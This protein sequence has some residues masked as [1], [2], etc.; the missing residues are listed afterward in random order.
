MAALIAF[1]GTLPV[2][3]ARWYL[4]PALLVPVAVGVWAWRAGTD[5]DATG[6]RVRAL[7]GERRIPWSRV[8]ELGDDGH[9]RAVARLT[10]GR[11]VPLPAVPASELPALV[12]AGGRQL[13]GE[14]PA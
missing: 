7:L 12:R 2:A 9:G 3:T 10:D 8:A 4:L 14:E 5:V 1:F 11:S 6:L 13:D